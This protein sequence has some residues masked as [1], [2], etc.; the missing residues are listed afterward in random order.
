MNLDILVGSVKDVENKHKKTVTA[1]NKAIAKYKKTKEKLDDIGIN[2]IIANIATLAI[3]EDDEY[4]QDIGSNVSYLQREYFNKANREAKDN[5]KYQFSVDKELAELKNISKRICSKKLFSY[6]SSYEKSILVCRNIEY[7][8]SQI[9]KDIKTAK[10][11]FT[12]DGVNIC[13][14]ISEKQS[15]LKELIA[16]LINSERSPNSILKFI[17]KCEVILTSTE[18]LLSHEYLSEASGLPRDKRY[19]SIKKL[20]RINFS[21]HEIFDSGQDFVVFGE[22]GAGKTTTLQFYARRKIENNEK[23]VVLYIP[24]ARSF[25]KLEFLK[26]L[27]LIM[28]S[29]CLRL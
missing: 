18:K 7:E 10:Y 1:N 17:N 28:W 9:E 5:V 21:I 13:K 8:L 14:T 27:N 2:N 29:I 12:I 3:N 15:E 22:A 11:V 24:L 4:V 25:Y 23:K 16:E 26:L 19:V 20:E 6:L